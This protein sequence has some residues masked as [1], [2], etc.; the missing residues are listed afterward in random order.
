MIHAAKKTLSKSGVLPMIE[1]VRNFLAGKKTYICFVAGV[2]MT[3]AFVFGG[4][5]QQTYIATMG[6]LGVTGMA[7]IGAKIQRFMSKI[8]PPQ[9]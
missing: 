8:L 5:D 9:K 4:V 3:A 1:K 6:A 7:T 2:A